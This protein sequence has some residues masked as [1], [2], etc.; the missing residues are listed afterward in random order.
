MRPRPHCSSRRYVCP[1][2][3]A[4]HH[5][6]YDLGTLIICPVY[7]EDGSML[8]IGD[9][10]K[11]QCATGGFD[12]CRVPKLNNTDDE[13][14]PQT[15]A[16]VKCGKDFTIALDQDRQTFYVAGCN[17]YGQLGLGTTKNIPSLTKLATLQK[18][19]ET[20]KSFDCALSHS[21]I[22]TDGGAVY[23]MGNNMF[24]Q[25][26]NGTLFNRNTPKKIPSFCKEKIIDASGGLGHTLFL[27]EE[28]NVYAC[29]RGYE[30]QLGLDQNQLYIPQQVPLA[31]GGS[32]NKERIIKIKSGLN[33]N[34]ALSDSG[35]LWVW[36]IGLRGG[37]YPRTSTTA[38]HEPRIIEE[39]QGHRII[40]FCCG[41][42]H[43]L[44]LTDQ[45]LYGI[46]QGSDGQLGVGTRTM[47]ETVQKIDFL[48]TQPQPGDFYKI[49]A[50]FSFSVAALLEHDNNTRQ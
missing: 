7:T 33:H 40:N 18:S 20:V 36:G 44:I 43:S 19:G 3:D 47:S 14:K 28:G 34:L 50:G 24:G 46:G 8:T 23:T 12:E 21:I 35:N 6:H 17:E 16:Q 37:D 4:S 15:L 9:N 11:G 38:R 5:F 27:T 1:S 22:I 45:G 29:G 25:L 39:L 10:A 13:G 41:A 31:K 2:I 26:G 42:Y 30:G 32:N 49:S 48:A